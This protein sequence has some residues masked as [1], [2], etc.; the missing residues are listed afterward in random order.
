MATSYADIKDHIAKLIEA[1]GGEYND[2]AI[3]GDYVLEFGMSD[4]TKV[5]AKTLD[6][7]IERRA[8]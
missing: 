4:P 6:E 2:S 5:D 1:K 8:K 3:V 7:M